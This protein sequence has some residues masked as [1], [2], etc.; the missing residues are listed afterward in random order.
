MQFVKRGQKIDTENDRTAAMIANETF[1]PVLQSIALA[2]ALHDVG[3]VAQPLEH[4][5]YRHLVGGEGAR[6]LREG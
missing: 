3:A 2:D 5:G 4:C 6:S 1:V